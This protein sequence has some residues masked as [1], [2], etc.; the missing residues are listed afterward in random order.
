MKRIREEKGITQEELSARTG[1]TQGNISLLEQ[2]QR[3][4]KP[5]LQT[6]VRI[7]EALECPVTDLFLEESA[8]EVHEALAPYL[9]KGKKG[10]RDAI[11]RLSDKER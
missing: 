9:K 2:G 3:P 1:I 5:S 11:N 10:V 6:L 7:A 4:S 8:R